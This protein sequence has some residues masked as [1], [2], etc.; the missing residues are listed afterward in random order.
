M[1]AA[2]RSCACLA[3]VRAFC[4]GEGASLRECR[5]KDWS[6]ITFAGERIEIE[7]DLPD[8]AS[9]KRA[10]ALVAFAKDASAAD[11]PVRGWIFADVG[12][13]IRGD[14]LHVNALAISD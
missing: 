9:R 11:I 2:T 13:Q 4:P 12:A 3:L 5:A 7:Y 6:S 1:K 8:A 14:R 10:F